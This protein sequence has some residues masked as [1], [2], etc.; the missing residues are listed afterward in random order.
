MD[1]GGKLDNRRCFERVWGGGPDGQISIQ[2]DMRTPRKILGN[3][4]NKQNEED[5]T[6]C[7]ALGD[8]SSDAEGMAAGTSNL[9][10]SSM[11]RKE[12]AYPKN[13]AK[14]EF[15]REEFMKQ[16]RVPDRVESLGEVNRRQN[17]SVWRLF[18]LEAD[19]D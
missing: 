5:W 13:E 1:S 9:D 3:V 4:I 8:P 15:E 6:T 16:S 17:G 2:G 18:L 12:G 19:P 7:R 14:G 11:V 10:C